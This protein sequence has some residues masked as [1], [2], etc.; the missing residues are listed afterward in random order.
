MTKENNNNNIY[1]KII[2]FQKSMKPITKNAN[3]PFYKSNYATLDIIQESIQQDLANAKLGYV[4]MTVEEG[5]KTILFDDEGN[6]IDFVYPVNLA[7]KPQDVGSAITYAKRY[8][9]VSLLGLIIEE[10]DDD[11]NK[12]QTVKPVQ[13]AKATTPD[14]AWMSEKE[15]EFAKTAD[16]ITLQAIL[17][18][19]TN[20]DGKPFKMKKEYR[21][22]LENILENL[23]NY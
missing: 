17:N 1:K 16:V 14:I 12:A 15:F 22:E 8:S 2:D 20:K 21:E 9:L 7:G 4:Q 19:K 5:L 3:N 23:I 11:G 18:A 13:K 6:T 10:E